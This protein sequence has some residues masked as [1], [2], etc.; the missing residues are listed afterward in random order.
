MGATEQVLDIRTLTVVLVLVS[1]FFGAA[2]TAFSLLIT[3]VAGIRLLGSGLFSFS[4]A[5][6]LIS[7]GGAVPA[8]LSVV[9]ANLLLTLA[10]I[11]LYEGM[12][13]F[14]GGRPVLRWVAVLSLVIVGLCFPY[15]TF[16]SPSV[17]SRIAVISAVNAAQLLALL[18][19]T[20]SRT[21]GRRFS[22]GQWTIA[23]PAT[24]F[25]V[26]QVGRGVAASSEARLAQL[27]EAGPLH[28]VAFMLMIL[29]T[30]AFSCGV[31][32]LAFDRMERLLRTQ[33]R[34]DPLTG[35]LN[36]RAM[37]EISLAEISRS[38]RT[39]SPFSVLIADLDNFKRI[40]DSHGHL[41]GD[42]VLRQFAAL[43][44][45]NLRSHDT[46][47]RYG[48]E[49][50]LVLLPETDREEAR[51]TAEKLREVTAQQAFEIDEITVH[52]GVSVGVA[53]LEL[54]DDDW[55]HLLRRADTA[56]YDA[57]DGGRNRVICSWEDQPTAT[58]PLPDPVVSTAAG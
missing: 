4:L 12:V 11:G 47:V 34:T 42:A 58:A 1:A 8:W 22:L 32:W 25:M 36:R 43:L 54:P 5:W 9:A 27:F 21:P 39:T 17:L 55:S 45:A 18:H 49:E 51:A 44:T 57:K 24:L 50:F 28:A 30:T 53:T 38:Q 48:G 46:L 15:F 29:V 2:L 23:G 41:A 31:L 35:T 10:W 56:L 33:S 40:N 6:A 20:L 37:D 19:A 14:R 7:I 16:V 52:V 3:R 26:Y 13:V